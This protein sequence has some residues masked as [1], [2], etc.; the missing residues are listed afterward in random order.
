MLGN[1]QI[2]LIK[3]VDMAVL[4]WKWLIAFVLVTFIILT[5]GM[6]NS[7]ATTDPIINLYPQTT[8][9]TIIGWEA[10]AQAGESDCPGFSTYKNA[11]F[12]SAV[13]DLGINRLRIEIKPTSDSS[14]QFNLTQFDF[15]MDNVVVPMRQLLAAKGESLFIN[16]NFVGKSGFPNQSD[17][18][19][20]AQQ[21]L[22]T[23]QHMQSKYHF[24][25][26]AWEVAL[27]PGWVSPDWGG[28][29]LYDAI[30]SS[31]QLLHANGF[32][33]L[34]FIAP[35]SP[36][37]PDAAINMFNSM[38]SYNSVVP[39]DLKEFAYHRYSSASDQTLKHIAAYRDQYGFNTSQLEHGGANYT[40]LH[41]DLKLADVS[42]WQ[43]YT[44][45]YCTSDNG[46]QYY[47]VNGS[48][49]Y[50]GAQAKYL[51]QYFKFIRKGAVRINATT[52]NSLFDPVAFIN[53]NNMYVVVVKA[54]QGGSFNIH[55]L[56]AGVYGVK[57]TT[58]AQYDVDNPDQTISPGQSLLTNIPG[59]GVITVYQKLSSVTTKTYLPMLQETSGGTLP[60]PPD[61]KEN[62]PE[63]NPVCP[64]S[65]INP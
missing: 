46:Y 57:F 7:Q 42:A 20:Y 51:R 5:I 54:G 32:T 25:P 34:Y 39:E 36:G 50:L 26:D 40:E 29:Q 9:Q 21:V 62:S 65:L 60:A 48:T 22:L 56:P 38:L 27:E 14:L 23:F 28:K 8:Y 13:N 63:S 45:A 37:G 30:I 17:M 55:G 2:M 10:V 16:V 35:S 59:Q 33:N 61:K 6:N 52:T 43:Q 64:F 18:S 1:I 47:P 12:Q 41:A 3:V 44:L 49:F 53:A 15:K 58:A 11:L 31:S 19:A 4:K 24:L